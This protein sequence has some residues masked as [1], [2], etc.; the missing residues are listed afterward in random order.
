M[1]EYSDALA[2]AESY[3]EACGLKRGRDEQQQIIDA[4]EM[5]VDESKDI[6]QD[7]TLAI[8]GLAKEKI[9]P[10]GDSCGGHLGPKGKAL[11]D[12]GLQYWQKRYDSI[13]NIWEES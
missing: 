4:L 13:Y 3:G 12:K 10:C 6:I 8:A 9:V 11:M 5:T 7:L 1:S 2:Y